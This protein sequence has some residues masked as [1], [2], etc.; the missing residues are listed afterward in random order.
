MKK[1]LTLLLTLSALLCFLTSCGKNKEEPFEENMETTMSEETVSD[2]TTDGEEENP[3]EEAT[4]QEEDPSD[5]ATTTEE[6]LPE[7]DA[8]PKQET[9]PK[10]DEAAQNQHPE[11]IPASEEDKP[12][13]NES[14]VPA[15]VEPEK[16]NKPVEPP[17]ETPI[18]GFTPAPQPTPETTT[19]NEKPKYEATTPEPENSTSATEPTVN[20]SLT[21]I[22]DEIYK[23]NDPILPAVSIPVDLNDSY[24]LSSYT[25]L[26]D[27]S[28]I[29]EAVASESAMGAQAYSLV[30]A[31]VNNASDAQTVA[32][33]M[34]DGI[35]QR[36]W[37]CVNADDIRV[38]AADD[39]VMLC[40]ISSEM[41]VKVNDMVDAF[42][43]VVGVP[44]STDI[45]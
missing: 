19:E 8:S 37:V 16:E 29:K 13:Q 36:K 30:L 39:I 24:S 35:N 27:A 42:S 9:P 22:I 32:K 28:L 43:D 18:V 15:P 17:A 40:M 26:T 34:R 4:T 10:K 20:A 44:F 2:E 25:G 5:E 12:T 33:N 1:L 31:R 45:R 38:V 7:E 41:D 23:I 6:N 21:G 3:S 11:D 14:S